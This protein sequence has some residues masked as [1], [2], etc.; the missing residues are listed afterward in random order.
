MLCILLIAFLLTSFRRKSECLR[1]T[2][3]QTAGTDEQTDQKRQAW[4]KEWDR[5]NEEY[6]KLS[7]RA[8]RLQHPPRIE[9]KPN[10]KAQTT[11]LPPAQPR[12]NS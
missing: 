11:P 9:K 3:T 6:K 1:Q 4:R 10:E 5:Q 8:H 12:F 7:E 2:W